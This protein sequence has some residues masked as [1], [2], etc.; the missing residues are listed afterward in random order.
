MSEVKLTDLASVG[1]CGPEAAMLRRY[2]D[3]ILDLLGSTDGVVPTRVHPIVRRLVLH[4][5][6]FDRISEV[7]FEINTDPVIL[8]GL[9]D[10][11]K[12]TAH[13]LAQ[14][15]HLTEQ[16]WEYLGTSLV[17]VRVVISGRLGLLEG[18]NIEE[19]MIEIRKSGTSQQKILVSTW[20]W[21]GLTLSRLTGEGDIDDL[22]LGL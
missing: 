2:V 18:P 3:S 16:E 9:R 21:S 4:L 20:L 10:S 1:I 8:K 19:E 22:V 15:S 17:V 12:T 13:T 7:E 14:R 5:E 6:G 11:L